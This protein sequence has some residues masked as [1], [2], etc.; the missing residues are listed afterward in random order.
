MAIPYSAIGH[1]NTDIETCQK[2]HRRTVEVDKETFGPNK[3]GARQG[4]Y[5]KC[6]TSTLRQDSTAP[7][8]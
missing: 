6:F 3:D 4:L 1:L 5:V 8:R 7:F 2:M